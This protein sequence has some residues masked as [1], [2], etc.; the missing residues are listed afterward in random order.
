MSRATAAGT[1]DYRHQSFI[2]IQKD[3][4]EWIDE[5]HYI[6]GFIE[7][8]KKELELDFCTLKFE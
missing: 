7:K 8:N 4:I 1:T 3:I 6:L 5:L 2:D